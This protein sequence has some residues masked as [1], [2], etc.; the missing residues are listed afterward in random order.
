MHNVILETCMNA[1]GKGI[2]TT[3]YPIVLER[4]WSTSAKRYLQRYA[5]AIMHRKLSCCPQVET[6]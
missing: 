5:K 4:R 3:L 1:N 6:R 2:V